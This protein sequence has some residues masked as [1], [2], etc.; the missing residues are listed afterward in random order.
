MAVL[1]TTVSAKNDKGE[2]VDFSASGAVGS[3]G[4]AYKIIEPA[5]YPA[6]V[7][8]VEMVQYRAGWSGFPNANSP[9]GK[10]NWVKLIPHFT[11][12]NE[13]GTKID[14]QDFGL[15][16]FEG[17]KFIRPDGKDGSPFISN[18]QYLMQAMGLFT[19][20]DDGVY[21]LD[22][23]FDNVSD[24]VVTVRTGN[25]AYVREPRL[26]LDHATFGSLLAKVAGSDK[27]IYQSYASLLSEINE[28]GVKELAD[29]LTVIP[30]IQATTIAEGMVANRATEKREGLMAA[31]NVVL[32]VYAIKPDEATENGW[33]R[34]PITGAVYTTAAAWEAFEQ[35]EAARKA[36]TAPKF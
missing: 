23:D 7:T 17:G 29:V 34:H 14:R 12:L 5:Y 22:I 24:R 2:A 36:Y 11:L 35:L 20:S 16:V 21:N 13:N 25:A 9:D 3:G 31:K 10:W 18:A 15:G 30:K 8:K 33:Y 19:P 6:V 4:S 1:A 26:N 32:S 27:G 28:M